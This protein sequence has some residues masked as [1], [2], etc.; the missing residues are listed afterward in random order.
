MT[1]VATLGQF[2]AFMRNIERITRDRG[3]EGNERE[4]EARRVGETKM[5]KVDWDNVAGYL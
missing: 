1:G 5:S 3:V 4:D 2:L